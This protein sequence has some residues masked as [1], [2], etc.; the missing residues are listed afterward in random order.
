MKVLFIDDEKERFDEFKLLYPDFDITY[1]DNIVDALDAVC[2]PA[3][4]FDLL[5]LDHDLGGK[6]TTQPIADYI[7]MKVTGFTDLT[8]VIHSTNS[9]GAGNLYSKLHR[10]VECCVIAPYAWAKKNIILER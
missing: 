3:F 7:Y 9:A 4:D 2:S 1:V 5:M 6:D 10:V 8:V